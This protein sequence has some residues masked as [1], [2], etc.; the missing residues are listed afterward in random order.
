MRDADVDTVIEH[1]LEFD[2]EIK[3]GFIKLF[4]DD[5]YK[6]TFGS[7]LVGVEYIAEFLEACIPFIE[8][9]LD[10]RKKA[11]DKYSPSKTGGAR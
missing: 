10:E 4:G 3:A 7:D 8:K 9:R 5:S 1:L 6:E 11:Y 2:E